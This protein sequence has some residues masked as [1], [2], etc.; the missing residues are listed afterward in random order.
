MGPGRFNV[1]Q[2]ALVKQHLEDAGANVLVLLPQRYC[3][4]RVPNTIR[5]ENRRNTHMNDLSAD[6][7]ELL[8]AWEEA[9]QLYVVDT[10]RLLVPLW[11]SENARKGLD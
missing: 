2:I 10:V 5:F 4:S 1:I 6:E 8:R 11:R 9:G 7:V 3:N